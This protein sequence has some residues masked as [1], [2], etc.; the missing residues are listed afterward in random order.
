MLKVKILALEKPFEQ[1]RELC[2]LGWDEEKQEI[3]ILSGKKFAQRILKNQ[4][5]DK[6]RFV[7]ISAKSGKQFIERLPYSLTGSRVWASRAYEED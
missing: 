6:E 5:L 4:Y 1:P 2:T 7:R 3:V